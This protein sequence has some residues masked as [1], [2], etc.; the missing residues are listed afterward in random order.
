VSGARYQYVWKSVYPESIFDDAYSLLEQF[1]LETSS[2]DTSGGGVTVSSLLTLGDT[3]ASA[4]VAVSLTA[5]KKVTV[6]QR[7]S[8]CL[9][10]RVTVN[11]QTEK[12]VCDHENLAT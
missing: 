10:A 12:P 3:A 2:S 7:L 5:M 1:E 9:N 6:P 8:L 4:I 11:R